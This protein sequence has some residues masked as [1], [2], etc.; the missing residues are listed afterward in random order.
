[1]SNIEK[2]INRNTASIIAKCA[3][4]LVVLGVVCF[5]SIWAWFTQKTSATADGI[6]VIAKAEGVEVSW[7]DVDYYYDLTAKEESEIQPGIKGAAKNLRDED[8]NPLSLQLVSGNGLDFF[9]PYVNR[10]TGSVLYSGEDKTKNWQGVDIVHGENSQGKYIDLDLYFK[11]SNE[12]NI[13]LAQDSSVNPV[14]KEESGPHQSEYGPFSKDHI[15][16][17]TRIAFLGTKKATDED[18]NVI[19]DAN[20]KQVD[21]IDDCKFI[22]APNNNVH[23][24]GNS[25]GYNR[26]D[27]D[28]LDSTSG[29]EAGNLGDSIPFTTKQDDYYLWLPTTYNSDD[30]TQESTLNSYKMNFTYY[31]TENKKGLYTYDF[32]IHP[33]QDKDVTLLYF[34]NKKADDGDASNGVEWDYTDRDTYIDVSKIEATNVEGTATPRVALSQTFNLKSKYVINYLNPTSTWQQDRKGAAFYIAGSQFR[35]VD[36]TITFGYNPDT[37][38]VVIVGYHCEG[39]KT[40]NRAEKEVTPQKFYELPNT[41]TN[42]ALVSPTT[43]IAISSDTHNKKAVVFSDFPANNNVTSLSVTL[44]EQFTATKEGSGVEATYTFQSK[45][46]NTKYISVI[47]GEFALSNTSTSFKLSHKEGFVGPVLTCK[48][49]TENYCLAIVNNAVAAVKESELD[50]DYA[51]T[52]YEGTEYKIVTQTQ[53]L[54]QYYNNTINDATGSTYGLTTLNTSSTPK[55]YATNTP[56]PEKPIETEFGECIATLTEENDYK[57]HIVIRIWVEGTDN[58]AQTP[59]AE[60][61]FD[62]A[63]HFTTKFLKSQ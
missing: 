60:G 3:V 50:L 32:V 58:E 62:I 29:T 59:L 24:Q 15:S 6:S 23:L 51:I 36:I 48:V 25:D 52:V 40:Y 46:D 39:V 61:I 2:P 22:W 10:R 26:V 34:I 55:L 30:D 53:T 38:Q 11:G 56:D 37:K 12:S 8:N 18:G 7:D 41:T 45:K 33:T 4:I 42:V 31:D 16:A 17:A 27:E 49:G 21:V 54:H 35:N 47:D 44:A 13:Y 19:L 43:S 1:M 20:G 9:E 5:F 63:L 28:Y 14:D 57:A